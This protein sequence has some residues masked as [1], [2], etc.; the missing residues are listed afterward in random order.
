M[1]EVALSDAVEFLICIAD[2]VDLI[3]KP[4]IAVDIRILNRH[5]LVALQR[6][7]EVLGIEHIQHGPDG[8]AGYLR[9]VAAGLANGIDGLLHLGSNV[10]LDEFLVAAE[11][12]G[13][14]ATDGLVIVG[15]LVLIERVAGEV[16]HAIVQILVLKD[17]FIGSCL[18]LRHLALTLLHKHVVVEIALVDQPHIQQTEHRDAEHHDLGR[19]LAV[20]I[21]QQEHHAHQNDAE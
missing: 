14:I 1:A 18:G 19:N 21:E 16:Q 3:H 12:G 7:D 4:R 17:E 15:C 6:Q 10:S 20:L 9:H 5:G 13:M 11:L 8:I 2:I